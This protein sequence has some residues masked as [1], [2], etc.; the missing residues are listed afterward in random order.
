MG[1]GVVLACSVV[2]STGMASAKAAKKAPVTIMVIAP[3]DNAIFN[4]PE[5][6]GGAKAAAMA[7][8]KA[9]GIGGAKVNIVECNDFANVNSATT[10]ARKAI[11]D[12]VDAVLAPDASFEETAIPLLAAAHISFIGSGSLPQEQTS[13][14][15]FPILGGTIPAFGVCSVYM[16]Q[17]GIKHIGIIA[18]QT[19]RGDRGD[20]RSARREVH[21]DGQFP[22]HDDRFRAVYAAAQEPGRPG[23]DRDRG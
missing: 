9:G 16:A 17:H 18:I 21:R 11:A 4:V 13:A 3:A 6:F 10:C 14:N 19:A 5:V 22:G 23:R 20:E 15:S 1:A 12:H 7:I 8:N 2:F